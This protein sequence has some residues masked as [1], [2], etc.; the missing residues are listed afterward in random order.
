MNCS[1][2]DARGRNSVIVVD[3]AHMV[4]RDCAAPADPPDGWRL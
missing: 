2:G 3:N 1:M 4:G